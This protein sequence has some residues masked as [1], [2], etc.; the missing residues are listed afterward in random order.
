MDDERKT[1]DSGSENGFRGKLASALWDYGQSDAY[2]F[3]MPGHKR[4]PGFMALP[5]VNAIDITEIDGFDD[6]HHSDGILK[7]VQEQAARVRGSERTWFVVNGSTCGILAAVSA[8]VRPGERIL[9]ARNCHKAV[10]NAIELRGLKP[11]YLYP[12]LHE[13]YGIYEGADACEVERLLKTFPDIKAVVITSPTYEGVISDVA[14]I[15]R[16][17]HEAGVPLIVDSAHGAHLGYSPQFSPSPVSLGADLVIESLHKTLPSMTQT[18]LL[19]RCHNRVDDRK[20]EKYLSMYETSSPSYVMMASMDQCVSLIKDQAGPLFSRFFKRL[21]SFY[22]ACGSLKNLRLLTP[23]DFARAKGYDCSKLVF[24]VTC[25]PGMGPWL[26]DRL[27]ED[28]HLQMEMASADYVLAMTSICDTDQG[29]DRLKRAVLALDERLEAFAGPK[30]VETDGGMAAGK[31]AFLEKNM[32]CPTV[33]VMSSAQAAWEE[34]VWVSLKDAVGCISQTYVY[35]YPPGIP[36]IV[37]GEQVPG[38][39]PAQVARL[40]RAGLKVYGLKGG[41]DDGEDPCIA[42]IPQG[43]KMNG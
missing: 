30:P 34:S 28:Y 31:G 2:P 23:G 14:A 32:E 41:G 17:A 9:L 25:R 36:M 5:P 13:K 21:E 37:P 22:Q 35:V 42:V 20:V 15:A 10:Y 8:C 38:M 11:V 19:H 18:A 40:M 26:Y 7:E 6:L 1:T 3:H 43:G 12:R 29:F 24:Y 33:P 4:N 39:M 27:R 16:A